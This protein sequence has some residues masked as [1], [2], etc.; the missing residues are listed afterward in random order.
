MKSILSNNQ[1]A[2]KYTKLL[3]FKT[4]PA[5][6]DSE[7]NIVVFMKAK[8]ALVRKSAFSRPPPNFLETPAISLGLAHT[9]ITEEIVGQALLTQEAT[10]VSGPDK[11]NFQVL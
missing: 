2:L 10:K 8:E 1:T 7:R 9:K 5:L 11:I 3:Q 4:T 6:K